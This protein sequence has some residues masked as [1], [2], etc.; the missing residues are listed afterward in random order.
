MTRDEEIAILDRLLR[1]AHVAL[2]LLTG[3]VEARHRSCTCEP[4]VTNKERA[5]LERA[6]EIVRDF[7]E[8]LLEQ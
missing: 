6:Q 5:N 1:E 7:A 3:D 8:D 4:A 2:W